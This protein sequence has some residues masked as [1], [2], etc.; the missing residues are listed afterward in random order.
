M[1][2]DPKLRA[3]IQVKANA[4]LN[5][6]VDFTGVPKPS[7]EWYLGAMRLDNGQRTTITSTEYYTTLNVRGMTADDAGEYK[8]IV[9]N[10]AGSA[11][12]NFEVKIKG[13]YQN[14]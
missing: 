11:S 4:T 6:Q 12:A 7:A 10:R 9:K 2:Y 5:I 3:P 8:V 1:E 14:L 13:I